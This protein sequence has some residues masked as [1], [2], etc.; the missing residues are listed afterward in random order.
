MLDQL[1]PESWKKM[2]RPKNTGKGEWNDLLWA[3]PLWF[4]ISLGIM[5]LPLKLPQCEGRIVKVANDKWCIDTPEKELWVKEYY[6]YDFLRKRRYSAVDS[7][8]ATLHPLVDDHQ[9]DTVP[10]YKNLATICYNTGVRYFNQQVESEQT[11]RFTESLN[12]FADEA[13]DF[14]AR[15]KAFVNKAF[16]QRVSPPDSNEFFAL[17]EE[18]GPA[19]YRYFSQ[20]LADSACAMF[21]R[22]QAFEAVLPNNIRDVAILSAPTQHCPAAPDQTANQSAPPIPASPKSISGQVTDPSNGQNIPKVIVANK[23]TGQQ[24]TT[25]LNGAFQFD[26][27]ENE[28]GKPITLSFSKDGYQ[29]LRLSWLPT[30][31]VQPV[32]VE[33]QKASQ[34]FEMVFT[35]LDAETAKPV[36]FADVLLIWAAGGSEAAKFKTDA[37]G[38]VRMQGDD[39]FNRLRINVVIEKAGY[40]RFRTS[41]EEL[42]KMG[43]SGNITVN[44][45]PEKLP[46]IP[47]S[48]STL[49]YDKDN[50]SFRADARM[51]LDS[52]R[53]ILYKNPEWQLE[54]VAH[55][56]DATSAAYSQK[57]TD[58]I[59]SN[60]V[61]YLSDQGVDKG[62]LISKSRGNGQ[63]VIPNDSEA[64]RARNRRVELEFIKK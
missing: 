63:P 52:I 58:R 64:N 54:I 24:K 46:D 3:L 6:A 9:L 45:Q 10:M 51:A 26:L 27:P 17:T 15:V 1:V 41:L 47:S 5:V 37:N 43:A 48:I 44:I 22:A 36:S 34:G 56:D 60:I 18:N 38:R 50:A 31:Y 23:T 28:W 25:G 2:L 7:V 14:E 21:Q 12:G 59:A 30:E 53:D 16:S 42:K 62:R 4:F 49:Y 11:G 39:Q 61:Q 33:M 57:L 20:V 32:Q 29:P 40:N 19:F 13:P 8:L 35:V 55:T